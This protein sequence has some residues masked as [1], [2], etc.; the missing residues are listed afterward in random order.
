MN[1]GTLIRALAKEFFLTQKETAEILHSLTTRLT[2]SLAQGDPVT[3]RG[4]GSFHKTTRAAKQVRHPKTGR[5]ITVPARQTV[6]FRPAPAL[7]KQ[8]N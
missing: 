2:Q 7:E 5:I 3:W 1:Q 6:S 8:T 4:F